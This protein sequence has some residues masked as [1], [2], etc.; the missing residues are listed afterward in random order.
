MLFHLT[1]GNMVVF[2]YNIFYIF[3]SRLPIFS[4]PLILLTR[5][6]GLD[7][8]EFLDALKTNP[9]WLIVNGTILKLSVFSMVFVASQLGLQLYMVSR[10]SSMYAFRDNSY[11]LG[12]WNNW[13]LVLGKRMFWTLLSP[14]INSPLPNDGTQWL[15]TRKTFSK[16][17][18]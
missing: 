18:A 9:N 5:L 16:K 11:D 14:L 2:V 3:K 7:P 1:L 6:E 4:D 15:L 10:G 17:P 13:Q 8:V 12:F